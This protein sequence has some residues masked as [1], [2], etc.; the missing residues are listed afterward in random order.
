M[1]MSPKT[2]PDGGKRRARQTAG[3]SLIKKLKLGSKNIFL[4]Y[5]HY[6][7]NASNPSMLFALFFRM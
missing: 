3:S 1:N 5:K 4:T 2:S 7:S 6:T